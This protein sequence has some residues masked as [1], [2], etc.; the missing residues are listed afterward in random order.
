M[1]PAFEPLTR[2]VNLLG[3]AEQKRIL[4]QMARTLEDGT[5]FVAFVGQYS[6]GKSYLI[7]NLLRRDLL[8]LGT[9]ETT[10]LLTYIRY[11]A[12]EEARLHYCD[13]AVQII[14]T[15]QVQELRQNS[16][17]WELDK[18]EYLEIFLPEELLRQGMI[19]LDTPGVNLYV[20]LFSST[21]HC[22]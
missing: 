8:P 7:N 16:S 18:L 3:W 21:I 4:E 17:A 11:G 14:S 10:P 1:K 5:Y 15:K 2:A 6:A 13:G 9:T 20:Y 22:L 12:H 19:F